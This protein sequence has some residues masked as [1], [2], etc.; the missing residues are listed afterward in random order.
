MG[1]SL[2]SGPEEILGGTAGVEEGRSKSS[3]IRADDA[4]EGHARYDAAVGCDEIHV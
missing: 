3:E 2:S 1:A 4:G